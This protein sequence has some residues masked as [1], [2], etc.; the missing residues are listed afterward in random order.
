MA[1]AR[2]K[3]L[4]ARTCARRSKPQALSG[5]GFRE[6]Q[7]RKAPCSLQLWQTIFDVEDYDLELRQEMSRGSNN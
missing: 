3:A 7:R 4:Q 2:S 1:R 5:L 6:M